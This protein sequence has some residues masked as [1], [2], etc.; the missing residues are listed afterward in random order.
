VPEPPVESF[1]EAERARL[2]PHFTNLDQPIFGLVNLPETVKGAL[3][4]RYSRYPGTLR[5]LFL[6]E[7]ADGLPATPGVTWDGAE[8]RRAAELYERVFVGFGDDSVAQLGGAHVACEWVS[9]V[10]TKVLQRPRLGAYLEQSTRYIPYDSQMPGGGYRYYR[11][12]DLDAGYAEAMD[13]LFGIYSYLLPRVRSWARDTFPPSEG[14]PSSAYERAIRAKALDLLRGLLPAGSLSHM[15]IFATGQT[16]EQLILHLLAHPLPEAR[17][18]GRGILEAM[19]AMMPSFVSRI[20]RPD[21]GGEWITYLEA[22]E[23]AARRWVARLGLDRA[24]SAPDGAGPSVRLLH[25]DGSEDDLLGALLFEAADVAEADTHATVSRLSPEQRAKLLSDLV[26]LRMNRRHR[27]GRGLEALRYRFEIVSDYGAF[28]DLQRHRLLTCQWQRLTPDLGAG[29]PDELD[30][31]RVGDDYRRGLE[32]SARTY[33]RLVNSGLEELAPYA[34]C[35]AYRI[36][37]VLDLNAREAMHLIELRSGREGHPTYRAVAHEM[38]AQIAAVHPAVANSMIHLDDETE[39]RL[40]RILSE[41]R[42]A[43]RRQERERPGRA[44]PGPDADHSPADHSPP[45]DP[46]GPEPNGPAGTLRVTDQRERY[47]R[48]PR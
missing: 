1:T 9:N 15:G 25:V 33:D 31:A 10:V 12:P 48:A 8:G 39:P 24:G 23:Q 46:D 21:R 37:Y 3:F 2:A 30:R 27:P 14:E 41:M 44:Q 45:G 16:Y 34:L 35:L 36:R 4:A 6:D 28:R 20:D 29:V 19:R 17:E 43:R 42:S 22:R 5:R 47:G 7:F 26:G 32:I 38:H 11:H 13:A 18:C 40:E